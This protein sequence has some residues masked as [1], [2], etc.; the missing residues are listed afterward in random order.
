M[1]DGKCKLLQPTPTIPGSADST[2]TPTD[3]SVIICPR[4]PISGHTHAAPQHHGPTQQPAT[5][6]SWLQ[7][8]KSAILRNQ[9]T[10]CTY[11]LNPR[12]KKLPNK[13]LKN[14]CH[15]QRLFRGL[16]KLLP[17]T[18]Q[19]VYGSRLSVTLPPSM[20]V[21]TKYQWNLRYWVH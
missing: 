18:P 4:A 19:L 15:T 13:V 3:S 16:L 21:A 2:R 7:D 8:S 11:E 14:R 1:Q 5:E 10:C 12:D 6:M 9:S 20:V 17:V